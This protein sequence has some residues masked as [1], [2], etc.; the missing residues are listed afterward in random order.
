MIFLF[1]ELPWDQPSLS[2]AEFINWK[3]NDHWQTQTPWSK[4]DTLA[5]SLLRKVLHCT[6]GLRM[7]LEKILDHKWSNMQFTTHGELSYIHRRR[8]RTRC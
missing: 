8:L 3:E 7:T 5:I 6:P 2:C 1:T 4:L